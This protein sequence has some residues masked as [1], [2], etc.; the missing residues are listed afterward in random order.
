MNSA[1]ANTTY[2]STISPL[3]YLYFDQLMIKVLFKKQWSPSP[4][5]HL[6]P[7]LM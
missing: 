3:D 2:F 7:A 1:N 6:W 4:G 5:F